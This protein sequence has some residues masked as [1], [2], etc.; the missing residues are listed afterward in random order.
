MIT[1]RIAVLEIR[2]TTNVSIYNIIFSSEEGALN[3]D[4][5]GQ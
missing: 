3:E 1:T 2:G 4:V 5:K